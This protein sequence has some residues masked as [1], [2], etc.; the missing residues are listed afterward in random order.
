MNFFNER[1]IAVGLEVCLMKIGSFMKQAPVQDGRVQS[2]SQLPFFWR[3]GS[4]V[5]TCVP[6]VRYEQRR[7]S[8]QRL[9]S[10]PVKT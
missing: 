8:R 7:W 5:H 2:E 6:A 9:V 1:E 4:P 3:A 10:Y